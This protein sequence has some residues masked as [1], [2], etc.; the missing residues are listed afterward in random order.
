MAFIAVESDVRTTQ[1]FC[2]HGPV[3]DSD[4]ASPI[5]EVLRPKADTQ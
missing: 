3:G 1:P 4:S 2:R 5:Y